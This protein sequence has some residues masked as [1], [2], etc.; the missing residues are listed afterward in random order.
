KLAIDCDLVCDRSLKYHDA[1]AFASSMVNDCLA[2]GKTLKNGGSEYDFV[3]SSNIGPS[4]VGDSLAAIKKLVF[5]EKKLTLKE[6]QAALDNNFE[7]LKGAQI[8][9]LC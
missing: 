6:L 9:K 4:V 1:D 7:G 5:D 8:R 3:S 2:K